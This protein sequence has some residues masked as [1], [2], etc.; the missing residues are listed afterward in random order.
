MASES[1]IKL[2]EVRTYQDEG[3]AAAVVAAHYGEPVEVAQAQVAQVELSAV[4]AGF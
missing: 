4:Q 3:K 2:A 1:T